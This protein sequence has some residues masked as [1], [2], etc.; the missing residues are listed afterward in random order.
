LRGRKP[1]NRHVAASIPDATSAARA[2]LGPGSTSTS[3]PAAMHACTRTSPGSLTSGIPASLTSATTAPA[4][5][6][7]TSRGA[8]R[9]STCAS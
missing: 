4:R 2:A 5:I 8:T 7:S 9:R 1:T 3:S 6:R